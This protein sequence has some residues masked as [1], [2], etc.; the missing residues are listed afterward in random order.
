MWEGGLYIS[1]KLMALG[2]VSKRRTYITKWQFSV[3]KNVALEMHRLCS[4]SKDSPE[5]ILLRAG[6]PRA[7]PFVI[8]FACLAFQ[9]DFI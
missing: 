9:K 1:T 2:Q 6:I 3:C 4:G 5:H 7:A 8:W